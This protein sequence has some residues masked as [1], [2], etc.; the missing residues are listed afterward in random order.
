[1]RWWPSPLGTENGLW[2]IVAL[3]TTRRTRSVLNQRWD[4]NENER[5]AG[6]LSGYIKSSAINIEQAGIHAS[7]VPE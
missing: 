7:G 1:M 6:T 2:S 5:T 4:G 3:E